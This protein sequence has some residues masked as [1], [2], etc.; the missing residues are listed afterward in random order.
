MEH[1]KRCF[2]VSLDI[3]HPSIDP[4][5]IS[6]ELSLSPL[7]Q[8]KVG[9]QRSTPGGGPLMGTYQF[10]F[11]CHAFETSGVSDLGTF[12]ASLSQRLVPHGSFF[13]GL[14]REG[15]SVE[16]FCGVFADGNWDEVLDHTLMRRLADMAIDLRLDVY[17][18]VGEPIAVQEATR[19]KTGH[20]TVQGRAVDRPEAVL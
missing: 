12:L 6:R 7:R 15:G 9:E 1:I 4:E 5:D 14:V 2:K 20:Y 19:G 16:L 18:A 11:W 8:T 3:T 17:P 10:S 13:V